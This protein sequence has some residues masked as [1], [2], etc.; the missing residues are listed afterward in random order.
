[1]SRWMILVP[2]WCWVGIALWVTP[3]PAGSP[4]PT[5]YKDVAAILQK[6]CQECHRP[7]QVAPFPLL[8]YEH[9]RK[10]A[11]DLAEVTGSKQ[12]P[13]PPRA[14]PRT[15]RRPARTRRTGR[16]ASPTSC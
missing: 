4:S 2:G 12:M 13:A 14:T 1:M 15:A 11:G 3:A 7:G 9:A 8:T 10:R 6:N 16:W 5:Y